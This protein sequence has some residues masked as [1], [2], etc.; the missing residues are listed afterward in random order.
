MQRAICDLHGLRGREC[1]TRARGCVTRRG[2][3]GSCPWCRV[4]VPGA[5]ATRC[6]RLRV[7]AGR[8]RRRARSAGGSRAR[9]HHRAG[10]FPL[11]DRRRESAAARGAAGVRAQGHRAAV[12]GTAVNATGTGWPRACRAT[13]PSRFRGRTARRWR[14]PPAPSPPPRAEWLRALALESERIANHLGDLGALGN[15]AGFA[16]GLAQFSRLKE[17][18]LRALAT[19]FGQRYLLDFVVPGGTSADLT[20]QAARALAAAAVDLEHAG[21]RA[22]GDLRRARRRARSIRRRRASVSPEL[23]RVSV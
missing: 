21:P 10:A 15:D 3:A 8:R 18:W 5:H 9:R 7:R 6:G 17:H 2:R 16:F 19:A 4:L 22:A 1:R 14:A 11:L 13:R 23:A 12:H 20:E